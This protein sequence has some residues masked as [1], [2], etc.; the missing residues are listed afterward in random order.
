MTDVPSRW[1]M[2]SSGQIRSTGA[3]AYQVLGRARIH[4]DSPAR[5][6]ALWRQHLLRRSSPWTT[7]S[8]SSIAAPDSVRW[9]SNSS[10][11]PEGKAIHAHIFVS[12]FHW[13]HIQG[14][15]FFSPLYDN[16]ENSFSFHSSSR[17]RT[18]K[19]VMEEQMA[20][21]Y[22]PVDMSE[23]KA[24]R[25]F[26][27]S[28]ARQSAAGW[29]HRRSHVAQSSPGLHGISPGNQGWRAGLRHRQ[30]T[31][32]SCVRQERAQARRRR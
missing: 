28:G 31:R 26:L 8:I 29:R 14:I 12:H 7:S 13:D 15:P 16:P 1:K 19:R 24:Q 30:R 6:S 25:G 10:A 11:S 18:L 4:A 2:A 9:G 17:T 27:Q 21:P 22:F 3:Y 20:A 32:R 5:Q 23:M